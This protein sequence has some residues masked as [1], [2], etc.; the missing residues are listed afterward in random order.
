MVPHGQ[1]IRALRMAHGWTQA[2]LGVASGTNTRTVQRMESGDRASLES[3]KAIA[4][5]LQV[6]FTYLI[7][8]DASSPDF[9]SKL[10]EADDLLRKRAEIRRDVDALL[11]KLSGYW[12]S[13]VK[14]CTL[15][16]GDKKKIEKWVGTFSF[17]EIVNAMEACEKQ[18]VEYSR[19]GLCTPESAEYAFGKIPAVCGV[20]R[21]AGD[22]PDERELYFIRGLARNRI[23]H[24]NSREGMRLLRQAY[25]A[26]VSTEKLRAFAAEARNWQEFQE[27]ME[28]WVDKPSVGAALVYRELRGPSPEVVRLLESGELETIAESLPHAA[29]TKQKPSE[30]AIELLRRASSEGEVFIT[31]D[32]EQETFYFGV[33]RDGSGNTYSLDQ[34][35]AAREL[36]DALRNNFEFLS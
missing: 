17:E 25:A 2:E 13:L 35:W 11:D 8:P 7:A 23:R 26:G 21:R 9:A 29:A 33:S 6:D 1:R 18:Y 5:A 15:A 19:D 3:L 12:E 30:A 34:P 27:G 24:F 28:I 4:S 32:F 10:A 20:T 14:G 36:A 16:E 22:N 31:I